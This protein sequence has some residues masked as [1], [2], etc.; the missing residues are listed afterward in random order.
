MPDAS[1]SSASTAPVS[2]ATTFGARDHARS[3][4][5]TRVATMPTIPPT[6]ATDLPDGVDAS[7]VV[8]DEVVAP[9]G[10]TSKLVDRGV[11]LRL[12]DL[13]GDACAGLLLHNAQNPAERL[14]VADTVKVQWQAY[15]ATGAVLLSD[16]G[17]ALATVVAD[18]S[19]RHDTFAGCTNR[20]ANTARYGDGAVEGPTP[21][22][23]DRFA[24]ALAKHGLSR[25]DVAPN[26]NLFKGVRIE[27]DGAMRWDGDPTPGSTWVELVVE[28]PLLVTVVDVPHPLDPRP[29][30]TVTPLRVTAWRDRPT[31]PDDPKWCSSPERERAY[32]NTAA[33]LRGLPDGT[34]ADPHGARR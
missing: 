27:S 4:A 12:T 9:G 14:N 16:M 20:A 25:R 17:R 10:Y 31:G 2:T 15:L 21:N 1:S 6:A 11:R 22:G 19:G 7:S 23:R 3:M 13:D 24:V 28:L 33:Y 8:W 5:G 32:Q 30:Y 18:T 29:A 34:P 26:V